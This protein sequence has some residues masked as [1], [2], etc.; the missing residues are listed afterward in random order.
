MSNSFTHARR[1]RLG[2]SVATAATAFAS[3]TV[4]AAGVASTASAAVATATTAPAASAVVA[5]EI[6]QTVTYNG[7]TV[8]VRLQP[9]QLRSPGFEVLVQQADGSLV[10]QTNL[11]PE[12][13][14]LGSVDGEPSAVASAIRRSDGVLAGSIVFDRGAT[15][16]FEDGTG[17]SSRGM[18][19]PTA[20]KWPSSTSAARNVSVAPGQA[21]SETYRWDIGFDLAND[22][23]THATI[24]GSVAK[25]LDSVEQSTV[26]MAALYVANAQLRPAVGRV[27]V[28]ADAA[29]DPYADKADMLGKITDEW[30]LNQKDANVDVVAGQHS[31]QSGGGLAWV[32]T[33]GGGWTGASILG[34]GTALVVARHEIGHN[35]GAHDNH[36]NGPEGATVMS[37]NGFSRFDGT[38]L[39]AIFRHRNSVK[40]A[41]T[42]TGVFDVPVP[43]YA[44]LDLVDNVDSGVLRRI[45]PVA[46]DHDANGEALTLASVQATSALGGQVTMGPGNTL[47]YVPPTVTAADTV[48]WVQYVVRD[49]SGK[50]ATGVAEFKVDPYVA[51]GP[52][53]G[54]ADATVRYATAYRITNQQSG[55]IATA[56]NENLA[57]T[58]LLQRPDSRL[59]ANRFTLLNAGGNGTS[60]YYRVRNVATEK[61][62]DVNQSTTPGS[63]VIQSTCSDLKSMKWRVVQHPKGGQALLSVKSGL[64]LAPQGGSLSSGVPLTQVACGLGLESAWTVA[65][66]PVSE[67]NAAPAPDTTKRYVLQARGVNLEAAV[68]SNSYFALA[69]AGA[70][71]PVTF[72]ANADGTWAIK[73]AGTN[74]CMDG[75]GS[76]DLGTWGC[77]GADNQKW[78]LLTHP[79]GGVALQNVRSGTCVQPTGGAT[80]VGTL[81]VRQP[82]TDEPTQ[83]WNLVATA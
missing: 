19:Q 62:M 12:R 39:S 71:L 44:A 34:S 26:E 31:P 74:T 79:G 67:W 77:H 52:A 32:G 30:Y 82:C 56:R 80:T 69:A 70:G 15:W 46:N 49:A 43:P 59:D 57:S 37:G 14:Y 50:T 51:P 13:G 7:K 28:R 64:C 83:R 42:P 61:C 81:L 23:F 45:N 68:N 75:Y 54:W 47:N 5:G 25:A 73:K 55:L 16:W 20:F 3:L 48:D 33:A 22:W 65:V 11:A 1:K 35:W 41:L 40:A 63:T 6:T 76:A 10:K 17:K 78:R 58:D 9:F 21:G 38:E 36:T 29:K 24:G 8:T 72:S 2:V 18:T 53:T 27:I 60:P 4:L 66:P